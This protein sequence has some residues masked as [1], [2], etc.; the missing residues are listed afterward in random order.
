MRVGD[1]IRSRHF[2]GVFLII[3]EYIVKERATCD[4]VVLCPDERLGNVAKYDL[5]WEKVV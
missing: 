5:V 4:W 1:L 2:S 3:D